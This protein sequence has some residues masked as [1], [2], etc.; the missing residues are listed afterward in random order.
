MN[1]VGSRV[2][3]SKKTVKSGQK[4]IVFSNSLEAEITV[5][6]ADFFPL[7]LV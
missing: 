1:T 3:E 4:H 5:N 7:A 2:T 6:L